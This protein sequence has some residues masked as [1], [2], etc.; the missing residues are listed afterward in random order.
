[1]QSNRPLQGCLPGVGGPGAM[2]SNPQCCSPDIFFA[3]DN[4]TFPSCFESHF[5]SETKCKTCHMKMSFHSLA[6]KTLF[7]SKVL[8]LTLL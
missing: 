2:G 6:N 8:H 3:G 5:Q 1:M 4:R 7:I